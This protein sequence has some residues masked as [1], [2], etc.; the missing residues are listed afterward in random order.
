MPSSEKTLISR[1]RKLAGSGKRSIIKGIG[2]DSAILRPPAGHDLLVTTDFNLE[3]THFR[4][5]WHPADSVGHR[6]L[7]RGLSDIA[8]MCGEPIAALLSLALPAD[9]PQK[10][11]DDFLRGFLALANRFDVT[12]AGGD[13]AESRSGILADVMVIGSAR[14]GKAI[15]RSTARVGDMIYATGTLGASAATLRTLFEAGKAPKRVRHNERLPHPY[16][17]AIGWENQKF[18][19]K[20]VPHSERSEGWERHFYPEPRLAIGRYLREHRL[21]TSMIDLSD[22]LS[23][24]LAHICEE[25]GVGATLNQNLIPIARNADLDLALHGGEDYELLFTARKSAKMPVEIAGIPVTEIGWITREKKLL[26]TDCKSSPKKLKVR[27]WE[28]FKK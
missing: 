21:A 26:I 27:G 14:K 6:C 5:E 1:I 3:G 7:A 17:E 19:T 20:R 12:L 23:T 8:A 22:G 28:H 25:S 24:D 9:L 2:D 11:V 4:R 13:I 15:Q 16:R 18:Q 10:W